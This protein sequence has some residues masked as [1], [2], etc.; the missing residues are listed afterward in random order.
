MRCSIHSPSVRVQKG[1]LIPIVVFGLISALS[2][3]MLYNVSLRNQ[4][5][6][7]QLFEQDLRSFYIAEAGFQFAVG[8]LGKADSY[9]Q[10]FYAPNFEYKRRFSYSSDG[11]EDSGYFEVFFKDMVN[12][13]MSVNSIYLLSRGVFYTGRQDRFGNRERNITLT[14]G[15]LKFGQTDLNSAGTIGGTGKNLFIMRQGVL[16]EADL[17]KNLKDSRYSAFIRSTNPGGVQLLQELEEFLRS[18]HLEDI[19]FFEQPKLLSALALLETRNEALARVSRISLNSVQLRSENTPILASIPQHLSSSELIST[20]KPGKIDPLSAVPP[21][22]TDLIQTMKTQL[23]SLGERQFQKILFMEYMDMLKSLGNKTQ[24]V[25]STDGSVPQSLNESIREMEIQAERG[26]DTVEILEKFRVQRPKV[27][28]GSGA[29]LS[30][31]EVESLHNFKLFEDAVNAL[32]PIAAHGSK[33]VNDGVQALVPGANDG[34]GISLAEKNE[35]VADSEYSGEISKSEQKIVD[36]P[37]SKPLEPGAIDRIIQNHTEGLFQ[38]NDL[39]EIIS[40]DDMA[41]GFMKVFYDGLRRDAKSFVYEKSQ[42]G[43][44]PTEDEWN[45]FFKTHR[46]PDREQVEKIGSIL[47]GLHKSDQYH[48]GYGAHIRDLGET[49]PVFTEVELEKEFFKK[50]LWEKLRFN[51]QKISTNSEFLEMFQ[52][53]T[54][55]DSKSSNWM[56]KDKTSSDYNTGIFLKDKKSGEKIFLIDYIQK[57]L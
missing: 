39:S 52:R 37:Y 2:I 49:K 57:S 48:M 4:V 16:R 9:T 46:I 26:A 56:G 36:S 10:R 5:G 8:L 13:D 55:G 7:D 24:L 23:K 47:D 30:L 19:E 20:L 45:I 40:T 15:S 17:S 12:E 42:Y 22:T 31:H 28:V 18:S 6:T 50:E 21:G 43:R 41:D 34:A 29:L 51:D 53:S 25:P 38:P 35:P 11:N 1:I 44:V 27:R 54:W 3:V 14:S 32:R 33:I